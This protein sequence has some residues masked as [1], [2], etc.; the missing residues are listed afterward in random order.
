L[1]AVRQRKGTGPPPVR[2]IALISALIPCFLF[3][4]PPARAAVDT[5]GVTLSLGVT[6]QAQGLP[7]A[8]K[9]R[10]SN[11]DP[12]PVAVGVTFELSHNGGTPVQALLWKVTVP[13]LGQAKTTVS[14][15]PSQWFA[16]LGTFEVAPTIAGQP[17]G[18]SV[19]MEV[20][21]PTV[22]APLFEDVTQASGLS[23]TLPG[24]T[25]GRYGAG[26][27]WGDVN[28]DGLLDL[29]V[30]AMNGPAQL[31]IQDIPGHFADQAVARGVDNRGRVGMGA[32]FVDYDNDGDPDLYV[33]NDG[34]NRLYRN[35]GTGHFTDVAVQAGVADV[36]AGP[37]SA[38]GDYDNDGFLDLYVV[39]YTDCVSTGQPDV[40]YH[41]EGDGTFTDQ[42]AL[43]GP[44]EETAGNGYQAAWFDY[45]GDG[46]QDLYL[47]NDKL[48][49]GQPGNHLWRNDGPGTKVGSWVF[50][51][52]SAESGAGYVMA[53]M[54]IGIADF[55][56][57]LDLDMA[58]SNILG[59]VIARN[60]GDGTFTNVAAEV[61]AERPYQNATVHSI[62]WGLAFFDF[63]LDGWE[64]LY[65][66]AG[67][68][69]DAT[70]QPNQLF[71]ADGHG[72]FLDLSAPS[73]AA[74]D[75]TSRG[76]AFADYDGDGLVDFYVLDQ[77][78]NPRLYHNVTPVT[79]L[80]WLEVRTVGTSSNRDGCGAKLIVTAG[81]AKM[82]REVFCGS[83][84]LSSGADPTAH[85][86]LGPASSVSRLVIVWPSGIRQVIGNVG[87]D[88][89]ITV[90][91]P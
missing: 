58:I 62:T 8:V 77:W 90:T 52:V 39:N 60:N 3:L 26:A 9:A 35:D 66:A 4:V 79:G 64:D 43:L 71:V 28:G 63:N 1:D 20:L 44:V 38:W 37:S 32:V 48:P 51:D 15:T 56:R 6:S 55:D 61:G 25:C 36:G 82:M 5:V 2:S 45:N 68:I 75:T 76:V 78:G 91:E 87:A 40:L 17:A 89:R 21:A 84:S 33:T 57:D 50:T 59:N 12:E 29:Y 41:N 67:S 86:G 70:P 13:G 73:Q 88:Q 27:S 16:D 81:A 22:G 53:A 65:V 10:A 31:W 72:K 19:S 30:P 18:A 11:P 42:T 23:T 49:T 83:V 24:P 46:R 7:F 74:D 80:H 34:P 85:F 47:A 54:G 69:S 14:I